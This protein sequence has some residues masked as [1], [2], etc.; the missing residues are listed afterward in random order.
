MFDKEMT[1]KTPPSSAMTEVH[2][3]FT[4]NQG[5][6]NQQQA[7]SMLSYAMTAHAAVSTPEGNT[8]SLA[9]TST[10]RRPA[11]G[12]TDDVSGGEQIRG[13]HRDHQRLRRGIL[14]HKEASAAFSSMVHWQV[15]DGSKA[16]F[17]KDR[18][19]RG[20]TVDELAPLLVAKVKTQVINKRLV[21]DGLYLN[22][23]MNDV[24]GDLDTEGLAQ[25]IRLCEATMNFEL[26]ASEED[27]MIWRW[28]TAGTYSASSAYAMMC[29]GGIGFQLADAIWK[30]GAP[31]SCKLFMWLAGQ[32]RVWTSDR[33][34]WHG[35]QDT[36]SP[37]FLC[38][39][40]QDTVDHIL[41]QCVYAR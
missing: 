26:H 14:W 13:R 3:D 15:G 22:N 6:P 41:T 16:L 27:R 25:L 29:D 39:Q 38:E 1:P 21:N 40:E 11:I 35:H 37:C 36:I 19:I 9:D 34:V 2:T 12:K 32:Y 5:T 31:L 23:W 28:N 20:S 24:N 18:W 7:G 4:G 30:S 33:R 10:R 17:W 8:A